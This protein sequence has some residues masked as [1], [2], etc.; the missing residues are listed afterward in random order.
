[1]ALHS[2][3]ARVTNTKA[4]FRKQLRIDGDEMIPRFRAGLG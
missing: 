1:M 4:A 3:F 2:S